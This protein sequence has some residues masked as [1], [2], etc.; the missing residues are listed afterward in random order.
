MSPINPLPARL[1][2]C[3]KAAWLT[4]I[5][6]RASVALRLR[7]P[8]L[9]APLLLPLLVSG[10]VVSSAS[11][12]ASAELLMFEENHC[13]YC[14]QWKAEVGVI[15]A[16]TPQGKQAPLVSLDLYADWPARY[17]SL[18]EIQYS[19]TFIVW[20]DEREIGRIVGYPGEDFFWGLLDQILARLPV[21][22][23]GH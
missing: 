22:Q 18:R 14:E 11:A 19:P 20:H 2:G 9:L 12:A 13:P 10:L 8:L 7:L 21:E 16:K 23:T 17:R 4:H 5:M 6:H 15:Y 3:W 1:A